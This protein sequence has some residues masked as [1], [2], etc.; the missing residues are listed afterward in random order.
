MKVFGERYSAGEKMWII[1]QFQEGIPY[2]NAV[3][4]YTKYQR[5]QRQCQRHDSS[6]WDTGGLA[7]DEAADNLDH[8]AEIAVS[9]LGPEDTSF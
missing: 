4:W 6:R 8:L 7:R 9:E 5:S 1:W 3:H 2:G